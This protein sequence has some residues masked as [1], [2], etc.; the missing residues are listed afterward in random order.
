METPQQPQ[1]QPPVMP[2]P[3][4]PQSV[5]KVWVISLVIV[6]VL[7]GGYFALAKYQS[8]WPFSPQVAMESPTP[9]VSPSS[10]PSVSQNPTAD[11]KTYT[12]IKYGFE[13]KYPSTW[14]IEYKTN[15]PTGYYFV[16]QEVFLQSPATVEGLK[17][18]TINPGYQY[19]LHF[20]YIDNGTAYGGE[21]A[22]DPAKKFLGKI[23]VGGVSASEYTVGGQ[24]QS[25]LVE[26]DHNLHMY[27]FS[28]DTA[29][30]K[31]QLT[32]EQLQILSTFRFTSSADIST[33]KTYTNTTI[34]YSLKYPGTYVLNADSP[35]YVYMNEG[36]N[37]KVDVRYR[38]GDSSTNNISWFDSE[39]VGDITLGG[40]TGKKFVFK[41]CD[42]PGC[43]PDTVAYVVRYKGKL[44]GLE[45]LG[46]RT[47]DSTE[48][49]ILSNFK[50]TQ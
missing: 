50:F 11:W 44:L 33:W 41:Y 34:G 29:W 13:F 14:K 26:I 47:L 16:D 12:N 3:I 8:M 24:G 4:T 15:T 1:Y 27:V 10:S 32:Q 2:Q 6:L 49:Q 7:V 40:I 28:F 48:I 43:G 45:F 21:A 23:I 20:S 22:P 39:P 5:H 37:S 18:K 38:E 35:N 9:T 17:A 42:G 30:D 36:T 25:Y 31:S 46:D 19:D